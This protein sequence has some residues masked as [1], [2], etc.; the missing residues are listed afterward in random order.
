MLKDFPDLLAARLGRGTALALLGRLSGAE[1]DFSAALM[2]DPQC[3][4]AARRRAQT[5]AA[6]FDLYVI[7]QKFMF[8]AV[9]GVIFR[10]LS[11]NLCMFALHF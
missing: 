4:E 1:N 9:H 10:F 6:R 11:L 7:S 2:I 3:V 8:S 5:R